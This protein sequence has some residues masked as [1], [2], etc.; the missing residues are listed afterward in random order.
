[1]LVH[2]YKTDLHCGSCVARVQPLLDAARDV[3]RWDADTTGPQTV[4][5]VEGEG[6]T[7]ERVDA[8]IRPAGF[9]VLGEE[10]ATAASG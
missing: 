2:R 4:L 5:T 6:I 8:L 1:M 7:A 10:I 3:K 9:H